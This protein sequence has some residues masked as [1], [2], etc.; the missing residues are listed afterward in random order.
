MIVLR[1]DALEIIPLLEQIRL[2]LLLL[3]SGRCEFRMNLRDMGNE[4][5]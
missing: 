1:V 5:T 4:L 3:S 2:L